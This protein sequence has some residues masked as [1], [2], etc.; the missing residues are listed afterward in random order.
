MLGVFLLPAF[1]RLGY[2]CQDIL[3]PS[4]GMHVCMKGAK[5]AKE[6]KHTRSMMGSSRKMIASKS[7]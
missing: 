1:T 2:E 3:S 4:D 7:S 5:K 6:K